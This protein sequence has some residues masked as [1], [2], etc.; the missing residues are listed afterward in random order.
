MFR[1]I[2]SLAHSHGCYPLL[3]YHQQRVNE[4]FERYFP[5][6]EPLN[7]YDILPAFSHAHLLKV[8]VE[9]DQDSFEVTHTSY[10]RKYPQSLQVVQA[11][12]IDY[13]FKYADRSGL[14]Q[15]YEQRG[16]SEDILI[17]INGHLTDSSYAN[18]CLW[19]DHQWY[20]PDTYL[21]NG[22]MRRSL[23]D[24]GIIRERAISIHDLK[25]YEFVSL[26]NALNEPGDIVIPIDQI[27]L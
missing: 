10:E 16:N 14:N 15:L 24:R 6:T 12:P 26:I 2:E 18:I 19:A 17:S 4:T 11:K 8:R 23:L 7:L 20:T 1:F 21:L 27:V 22:V 13:R 25:N 3:D 5:K 9:Y